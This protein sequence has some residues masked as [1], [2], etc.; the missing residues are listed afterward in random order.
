MRTYYPDAIEE[1]RGLRLDKRGCQDV[2]IPY[3]PAE[4]DA[5]S[6]H[7]T[8]IISSRGAGSW[9]NFSNC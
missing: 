6:R 7:S 8:K 2:Y 9:N 1:R 5:F 3:E 4:E